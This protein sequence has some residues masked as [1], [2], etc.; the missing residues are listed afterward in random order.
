MR[1]GFPVMKTGFSLWELTYREF[2][3]SL[4][5]FGF[6]VSVHGILRNAIFCRNPNARKMG[7][8]LSIRNLEKIFDYIFKFDCGV[9]SFHL[10]LISRFFLWL[11]SSRLSDWDARIWS[12]FIGLWIRNVISK[13]KMQKAV[14]YVH[15]GNEMWGQPWY[16]VTKIVLAYCEKKIV[17]VIER[18]FWNSR[19]KA[20]NLQNVWVY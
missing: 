12:T 18:N 8:V 10:S 16:F 4:T 6:A 14:R 13:G 20:E 1:T 3:V 5:G 19:L 11:W 2:P 15:K 17:L 9:T 7:N